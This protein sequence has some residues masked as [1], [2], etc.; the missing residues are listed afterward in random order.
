M[1]MADGAFYGEGEVPMDGAEVMPEEA[2]AGG[3]NT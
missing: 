3:D 2:I 1:A